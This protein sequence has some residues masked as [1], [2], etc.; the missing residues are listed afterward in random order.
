VNGWRWGATGHCYT[1]P[2]AKKKAI[3]QGLAIGGGKLDKRGNPPAQ[4]R[5]NV[6]K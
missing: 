3:A 6:P 1:G 5:V 2:D 4:L